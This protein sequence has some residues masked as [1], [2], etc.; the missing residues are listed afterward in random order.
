MR[1]NDSKTTSDSTTNTST[2]AHDKTTT[3]NDVTSFNKQVQSQTPQGKLDITAEGIDTIP[4]ADQANWGKDNSSS[5][6][7]STSDGTTTANGGENSTV[8]N[9]GK[10]TTKHTYT[11]T[12]NQGVNTYAHDMEEYRT[13]IIDV[14][15]QIVTDPRI[16]EL[17]MLVY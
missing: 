10:E 6:G 2:T 16:A 1:I 15:N 8:K 13:V 14:V 7:E 11:K 9:D 3:K 12:G 4:A 5:N 17:F